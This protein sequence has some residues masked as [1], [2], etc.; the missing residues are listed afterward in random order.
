MCLR[1]SIEIQNAFF[2]QN[3]ALGLY[4]APR[5]VS[6]T[7]DTAGERA[8]KI[9]PLES[10]VLVGWPRPFNTGAVAEGKRDAGGRGGQGFIFK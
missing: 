6:G 7:K 4:R 5:T 8:D 2:L 3:D 10:D 9:L 1:A